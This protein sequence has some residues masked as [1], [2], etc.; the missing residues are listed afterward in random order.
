MAVCEYHLPGA[1]GTAG[2]VGG[3]F[4]VFAF[5][6]SFA[7]FVLLAFLTRRHQAQGEQIAEPNVIR[8]MESG[9]LK[10]VRRDGNVLIESLLGS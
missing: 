2:D 3:A 4:L 5:L 8:R 7:S 1:Y 10:V 9:Q 6:A